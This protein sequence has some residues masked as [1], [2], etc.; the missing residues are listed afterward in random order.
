MGGQSGTERDKSSRVIQS[1]I[2]KGEPM[3]TI[4]VCRDHDGK[5]TGICIGDLTDDE[6]ED[7]QRKFA[8]PITTSPAKYR[9]SIQRFPVSR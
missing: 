9:A 2:N 1:Y 3:S 4:Q 6:V 8:R 5:M 7:I